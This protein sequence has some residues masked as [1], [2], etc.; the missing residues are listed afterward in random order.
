MAVLWRTRAMPPTSFPATRT[1]PPTSS[2]ST[3]RPGSRQRVS[4]ASDG[5]E[6]NFRK[7]PRNLGRRP[8]CNLHELCLEPRRHGRWREDIFVF[9]RQTDTTERVSIASDGTEGNNDSF[10]PAISAD[11]RYVNYT[12][13]ASNLVPA[14]TNG[15]A[16]IFVFDRQT[17]TTE[18]VSVASDGTEGGGTSF[19][20]AISADGRYVAYGSSG[21][22][23]V[24]G[25]TNNA[26]DVFVV[27]THDLLLI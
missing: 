5:T 10:S 14:D 17:G 11:G 3:G 18:Q 15:V 13:F 16:D 22:N 24:S 23:L 4:V 8:L 7:L 6:R 2:Y 26:A 9:D 1:M 12:S 27:D 21:S 19:G 25:D 20:S